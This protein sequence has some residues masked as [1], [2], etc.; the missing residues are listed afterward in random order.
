MSEIALS[1]SVASPDTLH[2]HKK[3]SN[4][5]LV[6]RSA[7]VG[8]QCGADCLSFLA[9]GDLDDLCELTDVRVQYTA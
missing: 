7:V 1:S 3:N 5:G 9:L 4:S 8:A 6:R 2:T